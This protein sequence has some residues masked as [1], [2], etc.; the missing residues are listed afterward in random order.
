MSAMGEKAFDYRKGWQAEP[1]AG[2]HSLSAKAPYEDFGAEPLDPRRY[3][4]PEFMRLE[5]Q[6]LWPQVWLMAGFTCDIPRP[7][8]YFKFD[9]GRESFIVLRQ[10]SGE[11]KAFYNVCP[12]RANALVTA[13]FGSV[14]KFACSFHGWQFGWDGSNQRVTDREMFRP[15]TLRGSIG[16]TAV[17]CEVAC[18]MVFI[19]MDGKAPP[20]K[21]FLGVMVDHLA[22]YKMEHMIVARDASTPWDANWKTVL[23]AFNEA[24]HAFFVHSMARKSFDDY[25]TQIDTYANG[26]NR[27]IGMI[28]H[29]SPRLPDQGLNDDL[30]Y[31]MVEAGLDPSK[32]DATD[33]QVRKA[34]QQAKRRRAAQRGLDWSS[35]T[36]GQLTDD[37]NYSF[38]PNFTLNIHVEGL[39]FQRFRPHPTD[40]E[41]CYYDNMVLVHPTDD[42]SSIPAYMG[43]APGTDVSGK[44]RAQRLYVPA[45]EKGMGPV[46]DED[47]ELV[48]V[49]QRGLRSRGFVGGLRLGEAERCI[50]Q[51]HHEL[52]RY[53]Y[54]GNKPAGAL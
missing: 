24:Y 39:L 15:E 12:H 44:T 49:V 16:L 32:F 30:K 54:E 21:D 50:R 45:G 1:E 9:F 42:A 17:R 23:D 13:D 14:N 20:L 35:F 51:F 33:G 25:H 19:N 41:K 29:P 28:G 36:D 48:P 3:Y 34:I 7:G 8:S 43:V 53:I 31:L 22:M 52:D 27:R 37:W 11:I 5:E 47:G 26:M 38:F 10:F 2:E 4:D 46:V 18:G 40:P 6:K